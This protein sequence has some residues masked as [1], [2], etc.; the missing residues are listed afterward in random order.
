MV[1]VPQRQET[2]LDFS[3]GD[4]VRKENAQTQNQSREW[5][6]GKRGIK[7]VKVNYVEEQQEVS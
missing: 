5:R 4:N 6:W 3:R 7:G 2:P 1:V